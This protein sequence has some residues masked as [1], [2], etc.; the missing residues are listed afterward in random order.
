MCIRDRYQR[1]VHGKRRKL[2]RYNK[3]HEDLSKLEEEALFWQEK[4][5]NLKIE[6]S[7]MKIEKELE[8]KSLA[9]KHD[10]EMQAAQTEL[11]R[12]QAET[13]ELAARNRHHREEIERQRLL[14]PSYNKETQL[15]KTE[16]IQ[17]L[18]EALS[19]AE[20]LSLLNQV[21]LILRSYSHYSYPYPC[22]L[23][24]SPSPRDLSTSR[25]PSSA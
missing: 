5:L 19:P 7:M 21:S 1:R 8:L 16:E 23:Y 3:L 9:E 2:T 20:R 13:S 22:L 14:P 17:K 18:C 10:K 12:I 6:S 4:C 25:M 15:L 11:H 24:T